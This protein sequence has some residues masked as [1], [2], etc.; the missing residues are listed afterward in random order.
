MK[1]PPDTRQTVAVLGT[2]PPIRALSSYCYEFA[3]ALAEH[4]P[5]TFISF[6]SIYPAFLYPGGNLAD[7]PTYPEI[8]H[9]DIHIR[10][11]LAWYN[12]L[13]WVLEGLAVRADLLH[14]QWWSLPLFPVYLTVCLLFKLRKKPVVF[15]VH[16]VLSH[17]DSRL[18][19]TISRLLFQFGS[20]FIVHTEKGRQQMMA[21]YGIPCGNLSVIPHGPLDF[22]VR[23][24]VD[25]PRIRRELGFSET[26]QII[27]LFGA[28]RPYKG[29][30]TAIRAMA[31]IKRALPRARLLIAGK[32]W[33]DWAPYERLIN[34]LNLS[35]CIHRH[36]EYIPSNKVHSYFESAD[37]AIFPY[38][39]FDSQSG[40]G[41]TAVSFKKPMI[42]SNVG[43][44]PELVGD[45]DCIVEPDDPVALAD[46]IIRFFKDPAFRQR[47]SAN[48]EA[49]SRRL[50]WVDIAKKT[51]M[52][53]EV[54]S[55]EQ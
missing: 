19:K 45:N 12:P 30:D 51:V 55:N 41:A 24:Q 8:T 1:T 52:V 39:R 31:E 26:D 36:L 33:E 10:R 40:A 42:V 21:H 54:T 14:A 43:G 2:L 38:R 48:L 53:Y 13:S 7:D 27:L 22:H 3:H 23:Q 9:P 25:K 46:R 4:L 20:H 50:D 16:N 6:K 11:R 35:G 28:I 34:R 37:L 17:D 5:V 29:L 32:L 49:V 18:Y 47:L 44:L 15:T